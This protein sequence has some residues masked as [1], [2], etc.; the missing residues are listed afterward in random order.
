MKPLV[1]LDVYRP[2]AG[3]TETLKQ[4]ALRNAFASEVFSLGNTPALLGIG[5]GIADKPRTVSEALVRTLTQ[6]NPLREI[7]KRIKSDLLPN[8]T[9]PELLVAHIGVALFA[10]DPDARPPGSGTLR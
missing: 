2:S 5:L 7:R 10:V 1:I 6:N 4:L 3:G 8:V 9:R